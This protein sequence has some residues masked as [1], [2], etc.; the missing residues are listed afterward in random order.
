MS[1]VFKLAGQLPE[2]GGKAL[3]LGRLHLLQA[4]RGLHRRGASA[5]HVSTAKSPDQVAF[6][7]RA[8]GSFIFAAAGRARCCTAQRFAKIL[9]EAVGV[10]GSLFKTLGD[11]IER[12]SPLRPCLGGGYLARG[13]L[14]LEPPRRFEL[15]GDSGV[16]HRGLGQ[17]LDRRNRLR[18][19]RRRF[20]ALGF[21][22]IRG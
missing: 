2:I 12:L 15:A 8:L 16:L 4:S 17:G 7:V 3:T 14:L 1:L 5:F 10:P 22:G 19:S 13:K 11:A 6:G 21:Q 9:R 20:A 18:P